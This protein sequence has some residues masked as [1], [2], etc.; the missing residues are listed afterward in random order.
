M[1]ASQRLGVWEARG[2]ISLRPMIS[3]SPLQNT[4][5]R[6]EQTDRGTKPA[7]VESQETFTMLELLSSTVD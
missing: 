4:V 5:G 7:P 2:Y 6:R 1:L 3:V